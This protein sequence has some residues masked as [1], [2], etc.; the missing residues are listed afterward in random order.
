M[1]IRDRIGV[2]NLLEQQGHSEMKTDA[3]SHDHGQHLSLIHISHVLE[4]LTGEGIYSALATAEMAARH[5]LSIER[6]G[7]KKAARRYRRQHARFYGARMMM[8]S[9]LGWS[10]ADSRR[11]MRLMQILNYWPAA[12]A[13][14]V[15]WVQCAE[16]RLLQEG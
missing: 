13:Q 3:D 14:M 10:L 4:P 1:C 9:L 2:E 8:H 5:I 6:V 15:E 7:V 12:A 11:S 16:N